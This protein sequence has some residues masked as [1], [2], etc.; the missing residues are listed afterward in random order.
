MEVRWID[1]ILSLVSAAGAG[2]LFFDLE[3]QAS[4]V[5][6]IE[7]VAI[8]KRTAR[9]LNKVFMSDFGWHLSHLFSRGS[10]IQM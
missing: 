6:G 5:G 2:A 4:V 3:P 8:T 1:V 7:T 9:A 10:T